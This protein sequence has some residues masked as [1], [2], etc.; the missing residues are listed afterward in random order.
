MMAKKPGVQIPGQTMAHGLRH[1]HPRPGHNFINILRIAFIRIDP[2][3][4]K[5]YN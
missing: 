2:K 3:S 5:K 1:Q 4:V